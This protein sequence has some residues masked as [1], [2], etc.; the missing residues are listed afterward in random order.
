MVF[1]Q[2]YLYGIVRCMHKDRLKSLRNS[3]PDAALILDLLAEEPADSDYTT[4]DEI[5]NSAET[6]G[7]IGMRHHIIS[8]FKELDA[9]GCGDYIVGRRTYPTRF[10]WQISPSALSDSGVTSAYEEES[11]A[12]T[13]LS[14]SQLQHTFNLRPDFAVTFQLPVD[15]SPSEAAR[16][17]DFIN[18][19]PFK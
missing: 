9:A 4:V 2:G 10:E 1:A 19:I 12:E 16:L 11:Y 7:E 15:I 14:K 8:V 13:E 3:S 18:T 5:E 17:S 6:Q